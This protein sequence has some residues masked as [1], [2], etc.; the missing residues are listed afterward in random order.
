M[1]NKKYNHEQVMIQLDDHEQRIQTLEKK[2]KKKIGC[3][4]GTK[5][6]RITVAELANNVAQLANNLTELTNVVVDGFQQLN[7]RVSNIEK[8]VQ[9]LKENAVMKDEFEKFKNSL[10]PSAF[11]TSP[12]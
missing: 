11:K 2:H 12:Q 5:P 8:D 10:K 4:N 7:H 9:Y 1:Y 3:N 6:P